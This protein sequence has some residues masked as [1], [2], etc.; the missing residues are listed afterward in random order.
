MIFSNQIK[1]EADMKE[2]RTTLRIENFPAD[3]AELGRDL[4]MAGLGAVAT[5]EEEGT[6]FYQTLTTPARSGWRGCKTKP[7][8]SS[9]I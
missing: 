8:G 4:W 5:V 1:S 3:V 7:P 6:K 9:T 2:K